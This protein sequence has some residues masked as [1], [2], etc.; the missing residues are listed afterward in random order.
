MIWNRLKSMKCPQCNATLI[1]H[2]EWV[3]CSACS[4][5]IR[6]ERFTSLV[7]DMYAPKKNFEIIGDNAYE[8]NN[9]DMRGNKE[10]E[11]EDLM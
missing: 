2:P 10:E 1:E 7:A 6:R 9:L 4:F 5:K 11:T 3:N 8:L